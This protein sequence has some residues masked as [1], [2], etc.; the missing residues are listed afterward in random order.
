MGKTFLVIRSIIINGNIMAMDKFLLLRGFK[1]IALVLLLKEFSS[2]HYYLIEY[3]QCQK[4]HLVIQYHLRLMHTHY[5]Y[6]I[7]QLSNHVQIQHYVLPW[8]FF[9]SSSLL[10]IPSRKGYIKQFQILL[11]SIF[12]FSL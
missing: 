1:Y 6:L 5:F 3:K 8:P 4:Y 12:L 2:C 9:L 11:L 7:Y 10:H